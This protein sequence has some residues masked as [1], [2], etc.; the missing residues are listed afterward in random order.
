MTKP[1]DPNATVAAI[2]EAA[3]AAAHYATKVF[4]TPTG[5]SSVAFA[6]AG[7]ALL[8]ASSA[9]RAYAAM[10]AAVKP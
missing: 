7:I 4:T 3:Q 5:S 6:W 9:L 2:F 1:T 10:T 8:G